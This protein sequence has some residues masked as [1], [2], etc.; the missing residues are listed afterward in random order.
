MTIILIFIYFNAAESLYLFQDMKSNKIL[1][2]FSPIITII[3]YNIYDLCSYKSYDPSI[4]EENIIYNV[5]EDK[6]HV[7]HKKKIKIKQIIFIIIMI[8]IIFMMLYRPKAIL[9]TSNHDIHTNTPPQQLKYNTDII[10]EIDDISSSIDTFSLKENQENIHYSTSYN[11]VDEDPVLIMSSEEDIHI[12]QNAN[13]SKDINTSKEQHIYN[14]YILS[15]CINTLIYAIYIHNFVS[16]IFTFYTLLI[17]NNLRKNEKLKFS[18]SSII[19]IFIS[20][21]FNH[22][23]IVIL[24]S[25]NLLIIIY[26]FHTN[27]DD[28]QTLHKHKSQKKSQKRWR[29][30]LIEY[31]MEYIIYKFSVIDIQEQHI[32]QDIQDKN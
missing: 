26:H 11:D 28:K 1:S 9:S 22:N 19:I 14:N 7:C 21:I 8:Y 25:V 24:Y 6:D 10:V 2:I 31:C 32:I 23:I 4:K 5:F 20:V 27:N 16:A 30:M 12:Q 3:V 18:I 17:I 13:T 29:Y 15:M